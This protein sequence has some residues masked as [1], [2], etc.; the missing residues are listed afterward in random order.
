[1]ADRGAAGATNLLN[2]NNSSRY[3]GGYPNTLK[4]YSPYFT[5]AAINLRNFTQAVSV[6]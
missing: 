5:T 2:G 4:L 1:M 3:G 6:P